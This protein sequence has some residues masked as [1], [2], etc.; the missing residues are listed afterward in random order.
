VIKAPNS[1]ENRLVTESEAS[2][3]A[4]VRTLVSDIPEPILH[5]V[6]LYV[7]SPFGQRL[8]TLESVI[9]QPWEARHD[10]T[11]ADGV[12]DLPVGIH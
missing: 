12:D 11:G 6:K 4:F 10:G 8:T 9:A 3:L 2:F 1:L 5:D 7:G